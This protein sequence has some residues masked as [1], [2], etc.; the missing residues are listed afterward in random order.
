MIK[1]QDLISCFG[2]I[3]EE[4]GPEQIAIYYEDLTPEGRKKV[5]TAID[6][7]DEL[8]NVFGDTLTKDKVENYLFGSEGSDKIPLVILNGSELKSKMDL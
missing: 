2:S 3:N 5:L 4:E 7:S 8:I 6:N 1:E